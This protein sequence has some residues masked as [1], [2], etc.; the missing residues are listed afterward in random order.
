M[1]RRTPGR[2]LPATA[3]SAS[4]TRPP[5]STDTRSRN[6]SRLLDMSISNRGRTG[7]HGQKVTGIPRLAGLPAVQFRNGEDPDRPPVRR[8]VATA[9]VASSEA[10][11]RTDSCGRP[12]TRTDGPATWWTTSFLS[13]AAGGTTHRTCSGRPP[14]R[15][16]RKTD[17]NGEAATKKRRA[18]AVR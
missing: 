7:S 1:S 2:H 15:Q 16:E 6:L 17:T 11:R 18:S 10:E 4:A 14:L 13:R 3:R 9:G 5:E 8:V 12:V